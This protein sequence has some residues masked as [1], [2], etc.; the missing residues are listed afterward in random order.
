MKKNKKK[1]KNEKK[2]E[3][4][5]GGKKIKILFFKNKIK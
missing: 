3:K 5:I 1:Q 4:K 2:N